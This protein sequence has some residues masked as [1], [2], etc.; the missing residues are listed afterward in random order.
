MRRDVYRQPVAGLQLRPPELGI[1][2]QHG[3]RGGEEEDG[4]EPAVE[5]VKLQ[6]APDGVRD[7]LPVPAARRVG[8]DWGAGERAGVKQGQVSK[9]LVVVRCDVACGAGV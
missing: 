3:E 4:V 8:A 9:V 1:E 5:D 7:E 2:Q 6:V